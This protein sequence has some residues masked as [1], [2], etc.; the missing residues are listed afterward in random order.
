MADDI[1]V[2]NDA[3]TKRTSST[4]RQRVTI[5]VKS[6]P[7]VHNFSAKDLGAPVAQAIAD[8]FRMRIEQISAVAPEAT[9]KIRAAAAKAFA[10]GEAWATKRYSGGKIG[11]M[12]PNQTNRAFNDSGRLAKSIVAQGKD[13][14]WTINVAGNRFD[15]TQFKDGDAG[16]TRMWARL[17]EL[18]PEFGN[19]A[20]LMDSITVRNALKAGVAG[21][22]A[23]LI[24]KA[25]AT[26]EALKDAQ[27]KAIVGAARATIG[28]VLRLA[29]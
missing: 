17:V 16:V 13:D 9:L 22:T 12:A 19:P 26:N 10:K 24:Q 7:L 21:A 23:L 28:A 18:V 20:L 5:S 15:P 1:V 11:P 3:L 2:L 4:G 14:K 25:Q 8:H 27:A 6:E 29:G